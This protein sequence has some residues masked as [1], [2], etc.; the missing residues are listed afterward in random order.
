ASA[1]QASAGY[2]AIEDILLGVTAVLANGDVLRLRAVP[3]SAMGPDLRRLLV[4]SEGSFAVV[5]EAVLACSARPS[6]L[7]WDGFGFSTFDEAIEGLRLLMH[8]G[9]HPMVVRAYD[10]ADA[11]LAFGR[12]GHPGGVV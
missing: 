7:A 2:G 4:G 9:I 1:G 8:A 6:S 5:T 10:E 3:R 12:M 11:T